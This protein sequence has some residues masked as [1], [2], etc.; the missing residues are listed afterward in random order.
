MTTFAAFGDSLTATPD[1]TWINGAVTADVVHVG[2]FAQGGLRSYQIADQATPVA[3]DVTVVMVGTNDVSNEMWRV[4]LDRTLG[5]VRDIV[6]KSGAQRA[7]IAAMPPRSDD[8]YWEAARL[9][10]DICNFATD[11]GWY[12]VDPW[13]AYRDSPGRWRAGMSTDRIHPTPAVGRLAG[14]WMRH[15]IRATVDVGNPNT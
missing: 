4:P 15:F 5:A 2:G 11:M 10:W 3:A 9:N 6:V 7:L 1:F 14:K 12:W 8:F 13:T